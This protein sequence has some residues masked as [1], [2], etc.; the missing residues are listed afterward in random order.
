M[1]A[2]F[3]N[4]D[5]KSKYDVFLSYFDTLPFLLLIFDFVFIGGLELL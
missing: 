4:D 2:L 1:I 5:Y 3:L